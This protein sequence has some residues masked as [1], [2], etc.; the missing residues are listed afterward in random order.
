MEGA[1]KLIKEKRIKMIVVESTPKM[2]SKQTIDETPH[3]S[4]FLRILSYG[5]Q[6]ECLNYI[7]TPETKFPIFSTEN[8]DLYIA[9]LRLS[10]CIDWKFTPM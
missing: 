2:W 5:Y 8:K 7:T 1:E 9:K 4:I 6:F 10:N 3:E